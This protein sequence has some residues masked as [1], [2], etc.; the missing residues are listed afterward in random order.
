MKKFMFFQPFALKDKITKQL[1]AA[2]LIFNLELSKEILLSFGLNHGW[3]HSTYHLCA[4]AVIDPFP[5]CN[6]TVKEKQHSD[7][8]IF[9]SLYFLP[10]ICSLSVHELSGA[11]SFSP[12]FSSGVQELQESDAKSNLGT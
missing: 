3:H 4:Q 12:F 2:K 1:S 5:V 6:W 7:K 10:T 8:I 9:L 11:A